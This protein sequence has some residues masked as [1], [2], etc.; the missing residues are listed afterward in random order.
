MD[1][2]SVSLAAGTVAL[3]CGKISY[4]LKNFVDDVKNVDVKVESFRT[5]VSSLEK[6]LIT[7]DTSLKAFPTTTTD[8]STPLWT[9]IKRSLDDCGATV[10]RLDL[11]LDRVKHR[12]QNLWKKSYA[13]VR[14]NMYADN[15]KT[16]RSQIHTHIGALQMSL[17]CISV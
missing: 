7:I 9:S 17:S 3:S 15:I 8:T 1:P 10:K 12:S 14:L 13:T 6:I 16:L 2:L 5:E 4:S 11:E